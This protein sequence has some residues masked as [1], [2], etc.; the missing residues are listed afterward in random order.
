MFQV[1]PYYQT[2]QEHQMIRIE[3]PDLAGQQQWQLLSSTRDTCKDLIQ[4]FDD[5]IFYIASVSQPGSYYEINLS[6]GACNCPDFLRIQ[7]CKHLAAISVHFPHLCTQ[8]NS[9]RDPV[10]WGTPNKPQHIHSPEVSQPSSPQESLKKLI[11][12]VNSLS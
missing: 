8:A 2:W 6:Q 12:E 10:F 9:S 7:Y 5:L 11:D 1:V 3:G 4:Q